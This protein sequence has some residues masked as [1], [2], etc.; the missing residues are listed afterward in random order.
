MGFLELEIRRIRSEY[1][2][3]KKENG[4]LKDRL[5]EGG[6]ELRKGVAAREAEGEKEFQRMSEELVASNS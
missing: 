5:I 4:V 1:E 3:L 2:N 6:Q